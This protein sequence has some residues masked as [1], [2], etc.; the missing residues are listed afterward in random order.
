MIMSS[1]TTTTNGEEQELEIERQSSVQLFIL[2]STVRYRRQSSHIGHK[3][4]LKDTKI[5]PLK[6]F[7]LLHAV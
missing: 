7:H 5:Q 1:G 6:S 2:Q 4:K 3:Q